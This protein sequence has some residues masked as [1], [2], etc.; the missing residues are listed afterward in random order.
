VEFAGVV[1]RALAACV[2]VVGFGRQVV[3]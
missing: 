1:L 2:A 3:C